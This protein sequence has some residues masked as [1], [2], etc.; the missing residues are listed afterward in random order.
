MVAQV[1]GILRAISASSVS[2]ELWNSLA[3]AS[4]DSCGAY[5]KFNSVTVVNGK[6]YL[7]SFSGELCVYG[8]LP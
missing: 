6:V 3:N 8:I 7:P 1:P 4:R 2:T 5:A